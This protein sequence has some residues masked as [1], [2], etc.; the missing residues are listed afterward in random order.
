[1]ELV[2][3]T[4]HFITQTT[5]I[6]TPNI[7]FKLNTVFEGNLTRLFTLKLF[8]YSRRTVNTLLNTVLPYNILSHTETLFFKQLTYRKILENEGNG[9]HELHHFSR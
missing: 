5:T 1:M 7:T 4:C 9:I 8:F 2:V 6:K 3:L